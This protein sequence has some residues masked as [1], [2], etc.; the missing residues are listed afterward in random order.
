MTRALY[1][2]GGNMFKRAFCVLLL[3][4]AVTL[5]ATVPNQTPD[6]LAKN[7]V[8]DILGFGRCPN[9]G[10]SYWWKP[11][12]SIHYRV[13]DSGMRGVTICKECLAHPEKLDENRIEKNLL[14]YR[15]PPA[16]AALV[17]Q[18]VKMYKIERGI[19]YL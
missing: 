11:A 4:I 1:G 5:V 2:Q 7:M 8:G 6:R 15:W 14:V 16:K 3:V 12:G 18:A 13:T 17:H 9:C 19:S 10:D